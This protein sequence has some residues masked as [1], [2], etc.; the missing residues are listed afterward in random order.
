MLPCMYFSLVLILLCEIH[1]E[2]AV[3]LLNERDH[4]E[5]K[6]LT[7]SEVLSVAAMTN[8]SHFEYVLDTIL[9]PRVVGT[10]NHQ[11][12]KEFL[13]NSMENLGWDIETDR[14]Q[15]VTPIFGSLVFENIVA[16]LNPNARRYLVFACHYDSKYFREGAF[17][18][19][20]DSAVP[21]AMMVNLAHTMKRPLEGIKHKNDVSLKFIFFDGEEAFRHWNDKDSIYGA[22]HLAKKWERISHPANNKDG[23][24]YLHS[25]DMLILLDLLGAPDPAFYSYFQ[26]TQRW[27]RTMSDA[28]S[29]LAQLG[30]LENYSR[31]KP[32]QRYFKM[33]SSQSHIE[34]DHLPFL[35]RNVPVLHLIPAP[36][37]DVWHTEEDNKN[38]VDF[39]T[40][41]NLN[42]IFRVFCTSYLKL[43][44]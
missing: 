42:K 22:R 32:E 2:S 18:G 37:P 15:A 17:V 27:Y 19:A 24:N 26:N 21:C 14:F 35:R 4:H 16:R 31:G 7:D 10:P 36:F 6:R 12:V 41:E 23:T 28:E 40:V 34:D 43:K 33:L 39:S 11:F 9:I 3:S 13:I 5:A 29:K 25:I 44:V 1:P 8:M 20:T 30:Q 38:I